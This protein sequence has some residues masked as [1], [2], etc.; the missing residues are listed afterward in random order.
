M[1]HWIYDDD[2]CEWFDLDEGEPSSIFTD[3]DVDHG[4]HVFLLLF[5]VFIILKII[6]RLTN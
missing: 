6:E 1:T 5:A 3:E 4:I 2:S